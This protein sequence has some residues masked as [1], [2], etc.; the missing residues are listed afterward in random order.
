MLSHPDIKRIGRVSPD[1]VF[2]YSLEKN[3][4]VY[5]NDA[6]SK[7]LHLDKQ[8]MEEDPS[9][10]VTMIQTEDE[11][12]VKHCYDELL[13]NGAVES[14]F[15]VLAGENIVHLRANTFYL[16]EDRIIAGF[17]KDITLDRQHSDYIVNYGAK[18]DTLLDMITHNLTG[19][20]SLT[21][22]IIDWMEK[23]E[24]DKIPAEIWAQINLIQN[25][26]RECLDIVTDF[27]KQEH[28][29]SEQI[30]VRKTRFDVLERITQTLDKL[31]ETNKD[32]HFRLISSL[33]NLNISTDS[34][35]FFQ[36]VHNLVSN[37]I[38]FT[39]PEGQIDI[40]VEETE[41]TFIVRVRDNGIG[42]PADLHQVLFE[43]RSKAK[44][45]GLNNE[46]STGLGLSIVK[47]LVQLLGGQIK[48]HSAE[49]KGTEFSFE[50]P[51]T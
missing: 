17:V 32:R 23:N 43:K 3:A 40:V 41:Q 10:L 21:Y 24:K 31:I 38:K 15:R 39:G 48:F 2:I 34:V 49:N 22:N 35:K 45:S 30:H 28:L 7:V 16:S 6:A 4:F 1:A 13:Q 37:A 9:V 20:L 50:L 29:D 18:K 33:R 12:Y 42:I 5:L 11:F 26:T 47:N 46:L 44:R 27:M 36:I 19:P 51:K 8:S 25:N 14:E